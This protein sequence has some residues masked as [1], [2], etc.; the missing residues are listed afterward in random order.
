[1]RRIDAE[2][3]EIK[4]MYVAPTSRGKRIGRRILLALERV[5]ER[6]GASRIVLETGQ[7]QPE[8]LALYRRSGYVD[9]PLFGEYVGS[10]LS[11]CL[12]KRLG[13][14]HSTD[15]VSTARNT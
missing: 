7:R 5:A 2:T 1:V 10:P 13:N 11:V 8:A 4:R 12:E 3:A 6:L 9:I 15:S 14:Q